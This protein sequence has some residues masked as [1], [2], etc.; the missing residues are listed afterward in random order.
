MTHDDNANAY[1]APKAGRRPVPARRSPGLGMVV[2]QHADGSHPDH[3]INGAGYCLQCSQLECCSGMAGFHSPLCP[4]A[5]ARRRRSGNCPDGA[6]VDTFGSARPQ[7][8]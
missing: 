7:A 1:T 2:C 3:L 5:A 6:L 8:L 4:A